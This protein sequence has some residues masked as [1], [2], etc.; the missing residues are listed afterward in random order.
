[1]IGA[2][3]KFSTSSAA[4]IVFGLLLVA[5][6]ATGGLT[7]RNPLGGA[8]GSGELAD[9]GGRAVK[10]ADFLRRL[11]TVWKQ[12]REQRP[13]L[14]QADLVRQGGDREV[15]D[16]ILSLFA[17]DEMAERQGVVAGPQQVA[18]A[19]RAIPAFQ[20]GGA[21]DVT[22]Y[23]QALAQ[24]R[25]SQNEFE[26]ELGQDLVRDQ[27]S[28]GI[29]IG[30]DAPERLGKAYVSLLLEQRAGLVVRVPFDRF[31]G[32]LPTPD[33]KQLTAFMDENKRAFSIPELR[34]FQ[35]VQLDLDTVVQSIKPTDQQ[36]KQ[37]LEQNIADYGGAEQ[38]TIEQ[39]LAP[40]EATAAKVTAR[41]KK[42]ESFAAAAQAELGLTAGDLALGKL[43]ETA[44]AAQSSPEVAASAFRAKA[45]ETVGPLKSSLG[46]Y[47]VHIAGVEPPAVSSFEAVRAALTV[48]VQR[49]LAVDKL[50]DLSR[51]LDDDLAAG[52][53]LEEAAKKLNLPVQTAGPVSVTGRRKDGSDAELSASVVPILTAVFTQQLEDEPKIEKLGENSY[54][55]AKTLEIIPTALRPLAEIRPQVEAAWRQRQMAE[56]AKVLA[57][58][59]VAGVRKGGRLDTLAKAEGIAQI[60]PV[61]GA[62]L[63]VLQNQNIPAVIRLMFSLPNG[64]AGY[65]PAERDAALYV[66]QVLTSQP[67]NPD[68]PQGRQLLA[69]TQRDVG[70]L[71]SRELSESFALAIRQS[72]GVTYNQKAIDAT[73]KRLLGDG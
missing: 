19:I 42:G 65:A 62:R 53:T 59:L 67:G 71:S 15:L 30:G 68:Q 56:R 2:F 32:N 52:A 45:G 21:F 72:L 63:Q 51:K 57:D 38:R 12:E 1:M 47:L 36:L 58:K 46:Y 4:A 8:T 23:K 24:S 5:L 34:R 28:R 33:E 50:Y 69:Q 31:A 13:E 73:R 48:K 10:T 35:Y 60:Q 70:G 54:Y 40:D 22:K 29:G 18:E 25:L 14:T 43:T 11:D 16:L 3:R 41:L 39:A 61:Q 27:F 64:Q 44:Y 20:L 17:I 7:G 55:V 9:V 37:A 49:E 6:V 66:V 26:K